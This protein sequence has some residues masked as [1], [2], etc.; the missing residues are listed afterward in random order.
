MA[1]QVAAA[2][3][4]RC[5][6]C[7]VRLG[8]AREP[9]GTQ[10]L[11]RG[12]EEQDVGLFG[13]QLGT[14]EVAVA[15]HPQQ[16][17][18]ADGDVA[19]PCPLALGGRTRC[20]GVVDV[21][22]PQSDELG[23]SDGRRVEDLED[24][25]VSHPED[26]GDVGTGQDRFGF[27]GRERRFGKAVLGLGQHQPD[28]GVDGNAP[29]GDQPGEERLDRDDALG[30][31]AKR[32]RG[33]VGLLVMEEVALVGLEGG[34]ADRGRLGDVEGGQ[35]LDQVAQMMGPS[36]NRRLGIAVAP[37]PRQVLLGGQGERAH[38]HRRRPPLVPRS[39]PT[40]TITMPTVTI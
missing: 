23:P 35:E 6:G 2:A 19:V 12:R 33:A 1:E 11:A 14:D 22:D 30:L 39:A 37:Q 7:D 40:P 15:G 8:G 16:G 18:G 3:L 34:E 28:G 13:H 10:R 36:G 27:F 26:G 29:V 32:Q 17:P 20:P 38:G 24:G 25:P 31:G 9:V 4:C 5:A 21:P